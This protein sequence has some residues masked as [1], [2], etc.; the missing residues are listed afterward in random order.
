MPL[1]IMRTED[2]NSN[3]KKRTEEWDKW[4]KKKLSGQKKMKI[5]RLKKN[6]RTWV[7]KTR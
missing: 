1:L 2:L 6:L 5:G 3:D 7:R 4:L